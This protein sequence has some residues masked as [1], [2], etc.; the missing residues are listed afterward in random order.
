MQA[1]RFQPVISRDI[2]LI[3]SVFAMNPAVDFNDQLRL[4]AIKVDDI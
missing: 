3:V 1:F 4:T 2:P